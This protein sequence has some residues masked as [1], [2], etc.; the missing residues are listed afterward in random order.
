MARAGKWGPGRQV[1]GARLARDI[2]MPCPQVGAQAWGLSRKHV[3]RR[4]RSYMESG[5]PAAMN[6]PGEGRYSART[7]SWLRPI[8]EKP[9]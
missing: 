7:H 6:Q 3:A 5:P 8:S 1:V 4:A 2:F 9:M